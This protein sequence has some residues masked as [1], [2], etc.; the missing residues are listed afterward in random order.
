MFFKKKIAKDVYVEILLG[1][2]EKFSKVMSNDFNN[3]FPFQF[4]TPVGTPATVKEVNTV[5]SRA[6]EKQIFSLW[7]LTISLP[8]GDNE[9]RDILHD[10]FLETG[11][12]QSIL[13][14]NQDED[15]MFA[16]IGIRYQNYFEAFN[17]WQKNPQNGHMIGTAMIETIKN[18]N[19]N[20]S[21]DQGIPLVGDLEAMQAFSLFMTVF[22]LHL[23]SMEKLDKGFKIVD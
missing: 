9:L 20:F 5:L 11:A 22:T 21:F 1:L 2:M 10:A 14:D 3:E 12:G 15:E 13:G 4:D 6:K 19:P 8:P 17:M 7:I 18:N 23:K 16:A